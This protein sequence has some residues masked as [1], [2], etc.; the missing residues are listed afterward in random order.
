M[1]NRWLWVT[2]WLSIIFFAA[3]VVLTFTS[4]G[5]PFNVGTVLKIN[6]TIWAIL[7]LLGLIL[8]ITAIRS[9][10]QR[11]LRAFLILTGAS[12]FGLITS[13]V[14]HNVVYGL[15][16]QWFGAD[17]WNSIGGD[18]P[19]FFVLAV[20]ICPVGYLVG[21]IGSLIVVLKERPTEDIK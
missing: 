8:L 9:R 10:I 1:L 3:F 19:V 20:L 2:F 14:L 18:E 13:L 12:A 6:Y 4:L 5:L 16:M 7:W 21:I 11:L 15:F 17:F